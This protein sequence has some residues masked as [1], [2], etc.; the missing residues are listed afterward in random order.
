VAFEA[1]ELRA[2]EDGFTGRCAGG[3]GGFGEDFGAGLGGQCFSGRD[4]SGGSECGFE[5]GIG[6]AAF[7][8]DAENFEGNRGIECAILECSGE[9]FRAV[10][11]ADQGFDSGGGAGVCCGFEEYGDLWRGLSGAN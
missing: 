9:E 8:E 10:P 5:V 6:A 7:A 1:A 2:A 4:I 11:T 3:C